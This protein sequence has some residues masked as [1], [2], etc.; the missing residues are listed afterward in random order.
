MFSFALV[1]R[2]IVNLSLSRQNFTTLWKDAVT[3]PA[4]RKGNSTSV[5]SYKPVS[6]FNN[7][8]ELFPDACWYGHFFL[9]WYL[10]V[11]P[12]VG[13]PVTLCIEMS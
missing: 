8:R 11:M 12:K 2:H 6:M 4:F 13:P 5:S 9:F 1:L 7:F 10:E 3:I